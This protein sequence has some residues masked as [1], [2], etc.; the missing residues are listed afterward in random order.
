MP[1]LEEDGTK[2]AESERPTAQTAEG[3]QQAADGA[4]VTTEGT[5]SDVP[6]STSSSPLAYLWTSAS[7]YITVLPSAIASLIPKCRQSFTGVS[8][9][10]KNQTRRL[11]RQVNGW[12]FL[13]L[14][15]GFAG[16]HPSA[17]TKVKWCTMSYRIR[18][19]K[20]S[21]LHDSR[22]STTC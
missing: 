14:R 2:D 1:E 20:N 4:T 6:M 11:L 8:M 3:V 17:R 12:R 21:M 22:K 9:P 15:H 7:H 5:P 19:R 13:I 18:T 16:Y 10:H